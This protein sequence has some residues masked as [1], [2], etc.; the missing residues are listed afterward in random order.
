[1]TKLKVAFLS[2]AKAPKKVKPQ[3]ETD[4]IIDIKK[5]K[6]YSSVISSQSL[7]WQYSSVISSQSVTWQYSSVIS[8]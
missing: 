4:V 6:E 5:R 8:S 2:F 7:T 3:K 1:M